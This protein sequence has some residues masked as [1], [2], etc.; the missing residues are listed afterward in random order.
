[1]PLPEP[2]NFDPAP[3]RRAPRRCR[4]ALPLVGAALTMVLT[5]G[6]GPARAGDGPDTLTVVT[7]NL[8]NDQHD[9]PARLDVIVP[10]LR[11]IR[12][13][14][15]CLQEVLQNPALRNQAET[16]ADSLGCHVE[17]ATVDGP[18]R[19]KRYGNA[20]LTPHRVLVQESRNLDPADDYRA[21]A[22]VRLDWHGQAIDAYATHLHHTPEGSAIRTKQI[23]HL[24][25]WV[26]STR[27][28]GPAVVAGDFNCELGS[29]ELA[30]LVARYDDAF[31]AV[32]P[33]ATRAEA[34]TYNPQF[35]SDVGAIDHIFVDRD[36]GNALRPVDCR[37]IFDT[38]A[39]GSVW[40]SD[41]FGLVARLVP[42]AGLR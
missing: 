4:V 33:N 12:P 10:E 8:W 6:A 29:P 16:L 40:A 25:A 1:M 9:W 5:A 23:R 3:C 14:V 31:H 27:G 15:L 17:F 22:H 39:A 24:L 30:P 7:L 19:P 13:D 21:V 20:I 11:R 32:H 42:A 36:R 37:R 18:E 26:D 38:P 41:H 2:S 28:T 34:A 35:G